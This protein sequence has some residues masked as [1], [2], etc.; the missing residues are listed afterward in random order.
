MTFITETQVRTASGVPSTLVTASQITQI[1][2][3][4]EEMTARAMNTRFVPTKEIDVLDGNGKDL[5]FTEKNPLLKVVSLKTDGS[6]V[7]PSTLHVYRSSGKIKMGTDSEVGKFVSKSRS[8]IV[9]YYYGLLERDG[10]VSSTTTGASV[11]G[12]S[13]TI[14]LSD[15]SSFSANDWVELYGTDGYVETA[16]ISGISSNDVT[17]DSLSFTHV[18]GTIVTKLSIP[19]WIQRFMELEATVYASLNAIGATYTF[20]A[21]YGLA[22]LNVVKGVPYTHWRESLEKALKERESLRSMIK[23]RPKVVI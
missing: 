9:E 16:Q 1:I 18:S 17:F 5:V 8:V 10:S 3:R 6:S 20:N 7:T 11:A 2:S 19:Q 22:D 15:A 21:S 12:T 23:P 14:T 4:V 13:I